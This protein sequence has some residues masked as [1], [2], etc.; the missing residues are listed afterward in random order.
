MGVVLRSVDHF[1]EHAARVPL[2]LRWPG[3]LPAGR[4]VP[5]VV[6]L[7]DLVATIIDAAGAP[8]TDHLDGDS[9]LPLA[10]GEAADWKDEAFAEYL[11]HGVARPMAML[12]RGR[13]KLNS[14]LGDPVELY[15]LHDDPGELHDLAADPAHHDAVDDLQCRFLAR[16]DPVA[17]ERR[18]RQ[19]QRDR[20]LIRAVTTGEDAATARRRWA[21]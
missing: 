15:D 8:T 11:G 18:V 3:M 20:L 2:A 9:L 19:S 6:S 5:E 14:S 13:Y 10:R 7:V 21:E 12:R 1:Y 4:R 17:I 16:W